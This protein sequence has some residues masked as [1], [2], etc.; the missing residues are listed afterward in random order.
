MFYLSSF[1]ICALDEEDAERKTETLL[2]E[3]EDRGWRISIPKI[4]NWKFH[5]QDLKLDAL[6][7]GVRPV[8][9]F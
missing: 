1:V 5:V 7:S 6:Y 4:K 9:D 2:E 3:T 8:E